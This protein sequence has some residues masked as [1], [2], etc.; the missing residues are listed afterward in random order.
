MSERTSCL[1]C[2]VLKALKY[3][4]RRFH[5]VEFSVNFI[6]AAPR[7]ARIYLHAIIT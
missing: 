3:L 4:W 5:R 6:A 1:K 7:R 2:H